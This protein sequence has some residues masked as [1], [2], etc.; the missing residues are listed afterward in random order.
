MCTVMPCMHM[1]GTVKSSSEMSGGNSNT[2]KGLYNGSHVLCINTTQQN[3]SKGSGVDSTQ[4]DSQSHGTSCLVCAD[5]SKSEGHEST[6]NVQAI[7]FVEKGTNDCLESDILHDYTVL[8]LTQSWELMEGST[9][10]QIVDVQ[11]RLQQNQKFWSEVLNAPSPVHDWIKDGYKLSLQFMSPPFEQ[12][13]STR[14][15][16][17]CY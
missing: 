8:E 16:L 14:S 6:E 3:A 10:T 5:D 9:P 2:F 1:W 15:R 4:E 17:F 11:G 7:K 12:D 13:N